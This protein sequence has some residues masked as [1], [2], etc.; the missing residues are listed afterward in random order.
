MISAIV[1]VLLEAALRALFAAIAVWV[2]L[3]LL[4]VGNVLVQKSAW[5]LV[6]VAA[7]AMPLM[8]HWQ[9]VPASAALKLPALPWSG[10]QESKSVACAAPLSR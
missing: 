9:G 4:R 5:G 6:L 10:I 7:L 2:G 8:P 3:R 1:P